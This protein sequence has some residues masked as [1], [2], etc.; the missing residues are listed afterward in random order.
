[1]RHVLFAIFDNEQDARSCIHALMGL[2]NLTVLL[3]RD[4]MNPSGMDLEETSAREGIVTGALMGATIGGILGALLSGPLDLVPI[5]PLMGTLFG[6]LSGAGAGALGGG[7]T[8]AGEPDPVLSE[9]EQEV[10]NGK[11]LLTI[12]PRSTAEIADIERLC[13]AYHARITRKPVIGFW[14][15]RLRPRRRARLTL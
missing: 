12:E 5:E 2:R 4:K 1:M 8:G 13:H 11:V 10:K 6:V 7:L 14:S 3:H 9:V 15:H